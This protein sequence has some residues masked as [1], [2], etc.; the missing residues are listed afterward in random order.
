MRLSQFGTMYHRHSSTR[1]SACAA[2]F[3]VS[4]SCAM[5]IFSTSAST[6]G[7]QIPGVLKLPCAL[8]AAHE[9]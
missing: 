1:S 7:S 9:K 2:V 6:A 3:S 4:L 8:L 5:I